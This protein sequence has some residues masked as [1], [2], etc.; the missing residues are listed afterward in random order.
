MKNRIKGLYAS[1]KNQAA[2]IGVLLVTGMQAAHA[3]LPA[4]VATGLAQVQSDAGDLFDIIVPIVL[5]ILGMML[6][7]KLIK[8]FGNKI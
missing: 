7:V 8:R 5:A 4:G 3:E 1:T 6:T 2:V